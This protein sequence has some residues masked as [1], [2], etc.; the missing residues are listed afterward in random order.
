MRMVDRVEE[1]PPKL[2]ACSLGDPG[3]LE[4]RHIQIVLARPI[5]SVS[6]FVPKS[7]RSARGERRDIPETRQLVVEG[8]AAG[9]HWVAANVHSLRGCSAEDCVGSRN[10]GQSV[11]AEVSVDSVDPPATCEPAGR[12]LLPR[13]WNVGQEGR[14]EVVPVIE[15][16]RPVIAS[17]VG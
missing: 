9:K 14:D 4:E 15:V 5:E 7:T 12:A 16:G 13:T 10:Y 2:G 6:P 17:H 1:L 8:S 11:A 3:R